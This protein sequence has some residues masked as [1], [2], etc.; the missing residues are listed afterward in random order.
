[1]DLDLFPSKFCRHWT[2]LNL[3][4]PYCVL[5]EAEC[6]S[7]YLFYVPLRR[8]LIFSGHILLGCASFFFSCCFYHG[9]HGHIFMVT[10]ITCITLQFPDETC[11]SVARLGDSWYSPCLGQ[12]LQITSFLQKTKFPIPSIIKHL[13]TSNCIGLQQ[14]EAIWQ[15][16]LFN[17]L[18]EGRAGQN[19]EEGERAF[20]LFSFLNQPPYSYAIVTASTR[21]RTVPIIW[22]KHTEGY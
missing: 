8:K 13:W 15:H 12:V 16:N 2:Y 9:Y 20:S 1:M 22:G 6:L 5:A 7:V 21:N 3:D 18:L 17:L 19:E 14:I 10:M 11:Y 4:E